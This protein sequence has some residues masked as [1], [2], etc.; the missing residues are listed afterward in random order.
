MKVVF[1]ETVEGSGAMGEIRDVTNGF[2]R[3]FLLPRGYAAPATPR[4]LERAAELATI[5][6]ERQR[7]EDEHAHQLV[8]KLD[9]ATLVMA[10]RVGE[11]G[12]L[13]GS[14]TSNDIAEKA[15]EILGDELDRRRI[16]LPEV[17]RNVGLYPVVIRLSRNITTEVRVAVVD[18]EAL[19]GVDAAVAQLLA[20]PS[21]EPVAEVAQAEIESDVTDPDDVA[22]PGTTA[23]PASDADAD[24]G[25]ASEVAEN[26]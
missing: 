1:L 12:R 21:E 18:V 5:E 11:Q 8:G 23:A 20:P 24:S 13:Y 16:L 15:G 2:A 4:L 3:N 10:V 22:E 17:I 19:E 14:V 7:L 26:S 6:G 25:D 9:E